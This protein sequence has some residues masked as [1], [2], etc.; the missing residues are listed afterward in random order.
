MGDCSHN[1]EDVASEVSLSE[2][3]PDVMDFEDVSQQSTNNT[4]VTSSTDQTVFC[5]E[6]FP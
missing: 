2:L 5:P 3:Q 1:M 6:C 4:S